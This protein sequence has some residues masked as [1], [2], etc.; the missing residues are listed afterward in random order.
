M[1]KL[2]K[3]I[4][5]E[6]NFPGVTV[7]AILTSDGIICIDTPTHPADARR[8]AGACRNGLAR[9]SRKRWRN[10]TSA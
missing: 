1:Q 7:G 5:V 6:S 8:W 3:D 9:R 2:A 4:Y 10:M